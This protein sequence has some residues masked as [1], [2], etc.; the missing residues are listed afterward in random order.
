[1]GEL[2]PVRSVQGNVQRDR[3]LHLEQA[4]ALD[5]RKHA[6]KHRLGMKELRRR[7]CDQEWRFACNGVVFT[8]ASSVAVKRYRYRGSKI[9]TPWIPEPAAATSSRPAGKTRG[10][11]G[12]LRGARRV[13]EGTCGKRTAAT[14]TPRPRVYLTTKGLRLRRRSERSAADPWPELGFLVGAGEGNRTLMTSLEGWGSTIELR[15][16][17]GCAATRS[18]PFLRHGSC[19]RRGDRR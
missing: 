16:R 8:G 3:P 10:A 11:P 18:V 9:P 15:P 13:R 1:M 12:A 5:T 19:L 7:F 17:S 2:L 6:G 4:D 14:P